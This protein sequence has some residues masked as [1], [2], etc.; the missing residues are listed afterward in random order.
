[1]PTHCHTA[2]EVDWVAAMATVAS[3]LHHAFEYFHWTVRERERDPPSL[4]CSTPDLHFASRLL[5]HTCTADPS[6]SSCHLA[7]SCNITCIPIY[8]GLLLRVAQH[9]RP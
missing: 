8:A 4:A 9:D 3:M 1:M 2:G 5:P 6:V 7:H